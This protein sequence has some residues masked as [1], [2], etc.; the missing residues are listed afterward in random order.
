M[1]L[2]PNLGGLRWKL[3]GIGGSATVFVVAASLYGF[4]SFWTMLADYQEVIDHEYHAETSVLTL[5]GDF[6]IQVQEWKNVLLRGHDEKNL[7]K[8]WGRFEKMESKIQEKAVHVLEHIHNPEAKKIIQQF[9]NSHKDLAPKYRSALEA[10][11]NSGFSPVAGDQAA[12]GIDRE[13]TRLLEQA[14]KLTEEEAEQTVSEIKSHTI[15][16]LVISLSFLLA[17]ILITLVIFNWF[18]NRFIT[19]PV[20]ILSGE[21]ERFAS[22]D[23]TQEIKV[24][25]RDELGTLAEKMNLAQ[26]K[27]GNVINDVM[28]AAGHLS[29]SASSMK[30]AANATSSGLVR[31]QAETEQVATAINEMSATV[32]EVARN[33][34]AAANMAMEADAHSKDGSRVVMQTLET[35]NTLAKEVRD[36]SSI[37]QKVEADSEDIGQVLQVIR[38]IAEQTNLLALNAAIEAARAGEQGRGFAVVADEV[39]SLAGR[40][41]QSTEEIKVIIEKLQNGAREAVEAMTSGREKTNASVEQASQAGSALESIAQSVTSINDMNTQIASAAEEQS[42][43]ADE[44]NRSASAIMQ[45]VEE[46]VTNAHQVENNSQELIQIA[47]NLEALMGQ[48]KV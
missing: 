6:K 22:G 25:S 14:H 5:R 39:R 12:Q 7:D 37:V 4:Y 32:Q 29:V 40:T 41:Q 21:L 10:Y 16:N 28:K 9:I 38:E 30:Q 43:V 17:A 42:A 35:I 33:T 15:N 44:I 20:K 36:T 26:K 2:K 11:R 1:K 45:V 18:S 13:P 23:F 19:Q 46:N 24:N 31:Q 48:F 8:Y 34:D 47:Q 3:L 27:L